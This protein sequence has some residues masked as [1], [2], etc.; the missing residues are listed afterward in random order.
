MAE[1]NPE[2]GE[3]ERLSGQQVDPETGSPIPFTV[4]TVPYTGDGTRLTGYEGDQNTEIQDIS[5]TEA[6]VRIT[7]TVALAV[8]LDALVIANAV[9]LPNINFPPVLTDVLVTY[10]V[11]TGAGTDSHPGDNQSFQ[12][13]GAGSGSLNPTSSAQGSASI[14]P[15]VQ[16]VIEER[17][18]ENVDAMEYTLYM[19][20]GSTPQD[21]RTKL[22][23]HLGVTVNAWPQFVPE[24]VTITANGQSASVSAKADTRVSGGGNTDSGQTGYEWGNSSSVETGTNVKTTR[25][26]PT[27][28]GTISIS[29][30]TE[31]ETAS[32]DAD[33]S[34]DIFL[35]GTLAEQPAITNTKSVSANVTGSVSPTSISATTPYSS[36]PVTG[37][38]AKTITPGPQKF[39]IRTI[40]QIVV[41][42][43][44]TLT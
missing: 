15:D 25:I 9:T 21:V 34:T 29:G 37:H 7:D 42:D 28:H 14:I 31:T 18:H 32:A 1:I 40:Y 6:K 5:R 44:A 17:F 16:P 39:G 8:I 10:N 3:S 22:S 35:D 30:P 36:I 24:G 23:T 43:F 11:N 19:P 41:V 26:S 12:I 20:D 38:Y 33:A 2:H 4:Q 13:F 27:I